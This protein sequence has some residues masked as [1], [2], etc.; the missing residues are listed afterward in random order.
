VLDLLGARRAGAGSASP[1]IRAT[2]RRCLPVMRAGIE[3]SFTG[4]VRELAARHG[5]QLVGF[6]CGEEKSDTVR[7]LALVP[8]SR[9]EAADKT[10][11]AL[12]A[13]GRSR[14]RA[15]VRTQCRP[16]RR[17]QL[18]AGPPASRCSRAAGARTTTPPR[19]RA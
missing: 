19:S 4:V 3:G 1:S 16:P 5:L 15:A 2:T 12:L 8:K 13:T 18:P 10:A 14:S 9:A 7:W 11:L 17:S 6:A